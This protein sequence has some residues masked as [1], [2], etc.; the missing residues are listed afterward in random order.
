M[1]N[2]VEEASGKVAKAAG[3]VEE[4]RLCN[5]GWMINQEEEKKNGTQIVQKGGRKGKEE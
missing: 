3:A 4:A 1:S 2:T 5:R